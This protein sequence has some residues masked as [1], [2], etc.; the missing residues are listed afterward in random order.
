M[1]E[2]GCWGCELTWTR[3]V[4]ITDIR[5]KDFVDSSTFLVLAA[6]TS[7]DFEKFQLVAINASGRRSRN[8][9]AW[10][11]GSLML[12][13]LVN[14]TEGFIA[15]VTS[16]WLNVLSIEMLPCAKRVNIT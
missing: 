12:N 7:L 3:K 11:V 16:V 1:T 10:W 2:A 6:T 4:L 15:T 14:I 9:L 5:P 13:Q 8:N